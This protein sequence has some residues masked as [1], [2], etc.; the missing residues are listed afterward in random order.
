MNSHI[1]T[2]GAY[3]RARREALGL[4]QV[5][6]AREVRRRGR[7]HA[8]RQLRREKDAAKHHAKAV[9]EDR[10]RLGGLDDCAAHPAES[11]GQALHLSGLAGTVHSLES[12]K[13]TAGCHWESPL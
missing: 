10:V 2:H 3:I 4:S 5:A 7:L 1:G 8:R 13:E 6:L 12:N 11:R 9:M